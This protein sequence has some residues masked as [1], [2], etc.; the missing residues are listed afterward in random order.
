MHR[1]SI[2]EQEIRQQTKKLV[3]DFTEKDLSTLNQM[4]RI[5]LVRDIVIDRILN[6]EKQQNSGK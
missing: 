1:Y 5:E 4:K 2:I 6:I 3:K